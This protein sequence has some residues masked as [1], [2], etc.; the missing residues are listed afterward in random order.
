MIHTQQIDQT[1][2]QQVSS[3]E[4]LCGSIR[5]TVK[6]DINLIMLTVKNGISVMR[7][8]QND[9]SLINLKYRKWHQFNQLKYQEW[10]QF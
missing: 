1:T 10:R 9:I 4:L 5:K 6:S 8:C 2:R 7:N 3:M